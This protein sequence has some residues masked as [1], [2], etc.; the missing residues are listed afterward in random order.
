MEDGE[1]RTD[2]VGEAEQVELGTEFAMVAPLGFLEPVQV[3]GERLRALPR[4]AVDAL[5]LRTL[6]VAAPVRTRDAHQFERAE[7]ARGRHVRTATQVGEVDRSVGVDVAIHTHAAA[8]ADLFGLLLVGRALPHLRDDLLLERLVAEQRDA[9]VVVELLAFEALVVGNDLAHLV[10]DASEVVLGERLAAGKL[11]VV[12]EAV[13]DRGPDRVL[14]A[15]KQLDD[16]LCEHVRGAV[17]Q[18]LTALVA[19]RRDDRDARVARDRPVEVDPLAVDACR[20]GVLREARTDRSRDLGRRRARRDLAG[21]RIG[22][23][24]RDLLSHSGWILRAS[25]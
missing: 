23:R 3:F 11:E 21:R 17:P 10:F 7:P 18:H 1:P 5:E 20:D 19:G 12:I 14:G 2:L 24:D 9:R 8:V 25:L 6:L 13:G 4:R 15:G 16:G 22:Q